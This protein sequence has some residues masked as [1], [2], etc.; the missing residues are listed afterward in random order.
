[1]RKSICITGI[2]LIVLF[3]PVN[4]A[5]SQSIG[6]QGV[7]G[8]LSFVD[9]E[10]TSGVIGVGG[11]V[12]LGTLTNNVVLY[13]SIEYWSKSGFNQ[14]AFNGDVRY[15]VP[16]EV[17]CLRGESPSL[18]VGQAESTTPHLFLQDP[19]LLDPVCDDVLL[20]TVITQPEKVQSNT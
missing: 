8:R 7:G 10:G 9:P 16:T 20:M 14:V 2:F 3:M 12:D 5:F 13:P 11:H 17:L 19:V 18:L 1:M 6:L 15:Y 4:S